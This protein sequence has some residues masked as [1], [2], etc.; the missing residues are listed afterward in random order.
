MTLV[1]P[2]LLLLLPFECSLACTARFGLCSKEKSTEAIG[3]R[4][5]FPE[6]SIKD[7]TD[8]RSCRNNVTKV[9]HKTLLEERATALSNART[10]NVNCGLPLTSDASSRGV[11]AI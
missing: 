9:Q 6:N 4:E 5:P 11:E 7:E 3:R 8:H 2:L 1:A 10:K